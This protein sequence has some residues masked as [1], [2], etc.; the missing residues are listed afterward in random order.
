MLRYVSIFLPMILLLYAADA[1]AQKFRKA[2]DGESRK[3]EIR[4]TAKY[5]ICI[6]GDHRGVNVPYIVAS[7]SGL[8]TKGANIQVTYKGGDYLDAAHYEG[9][10]QVI[11]SL[12]SNGT[13]ASRMI[14]VP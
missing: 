9:L 11:T 2:R 5:P 13:E 12:K 6:A 4:K 10:I 7:G 1:E 8:K 3:L 14:I